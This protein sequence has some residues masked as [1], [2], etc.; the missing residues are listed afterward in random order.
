MIGEKSSACALVFPLASKRKKVVI[1][2]WNLGKT[3]LPFNTRG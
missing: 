1:L 3:V 2:T